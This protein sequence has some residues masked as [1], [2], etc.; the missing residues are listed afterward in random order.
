MER[1]VKVLIQDIEKYLEKKKHKIGNA[2]S[3]FDRGQRE[4]ISQI[5]EEVK[6]TREAIR[7]KEM[8]WRAVGN[9]Y[10]LSGDHFWELLFPYQWV[11]YTCKYFPEAINNRLLSII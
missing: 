5:S 11:I 6:K 3:G 10:Y 4:L 7:G 1:I 9:Y 8:K 2:S